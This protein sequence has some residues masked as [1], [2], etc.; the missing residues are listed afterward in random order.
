MDSSKFKYG[1]DLLYKEPQLKCMLTGTLEYRVCLK[2]VCR[3]NCAISN[4][5]DTFTLKGLVIS[6]ELMLKRT[7]ELQLYHNKIHLR[8]KD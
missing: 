4:N 5:R 6:L 8:L 3:Y 2:D 7:L 1:V